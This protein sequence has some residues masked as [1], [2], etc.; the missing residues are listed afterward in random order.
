MEQLQ[1]SNNLEK[2]LNIARHASGEERD[3]IFSYIKE[4]NSRVFY[5]NNPHVWISDFLGIDINTIDWSLNKEYKNHKWDGTP[6]PIKEICISLANWNNTAVEAATG[7]SKSFIAGCL[8][9]WFLDCYPETSK[10]LTVAPKGAQLANIWEHIQTRFYKFRRI[11]PDA[12]L[13]KSLELRM[14]GK[15]DDR[16]KSWFG[17]GVTAEVSS[18]EQIAGNARGFHAPHMLII[19][20]ETNKV[21]DSI[22]KALELTCSD[23]KNILLYLG[24]PDNEN[25]SLHRRFKRKS[26]KSIT[27]S[28][29]DYPNVVMKN[30]SFIP[31][32]TS[33]KF[34]N[35]LIEECKEETFDYKNHPLYL[36]RVRGICPV[37]SN[38]TL[39]P[40]NCLSKVSDWFENKYK[41]PIKLKTHIE[42]E[43]TTL[44]G[45]TKYYE[46]PHEKWAYRYILA[47][48]VA[49]SGGGRDWHSA[50]MFDR[51]KK[52]VLAVIRM[53][54][55]Q[56]YY[57][58][59]IVDLCNSYTVI[60]ENTGEFFYPML[61]WETNGVGQLIGYDAIK[62][63]PYKYFRQTIQKD[64]PKPREV[65][66]WWTGK[67]EREDI[68]TR[69]KQWG[70]QLIF[71]PE[72]VR[73]LDLFSELKTLVWNEDRNRFEAQSGFHDDLGFS[74][75]GISLEVDNQLKASGIIP[76]KLVEERKFD[77]IQKIIDIRNKRKNKKLVLP[78][79]L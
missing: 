68:S 39:I 42:K 20:D 54:G 55:T 47:C 50:I 29:L 18:G 31:G 75:L 12:F 71:H 35:S 30:P 15:D 1:I 2:L 25:D 51:L 56:D 32:A 17:M 36:S 74:A 26:V 10:V 7:V 44:E 23:P 22:V 40:F 60:N 66:G 33:E 9:L 53:R 5:Q 52:E 61:V 49:G 21:S 24:N 28:A 72:R 59:E 64:N 14:F 78:K 38:D 34:I 6:N 37:T 43:N 8:T 46:I 19:I 41:E 11:R 77:H 62:K 67:N 76:I 65:P 69:I 58:K 13:M 16:S 48:D 45:T 70:L 27:I 4:I 63:Y 3:D 79:C 73:D 57:V